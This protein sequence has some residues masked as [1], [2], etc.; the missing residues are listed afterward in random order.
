VVHSN[1]QNFDRV[2][3]ASRR[4]RRVVTRR[5]YQDITTYTWRFGAATVNNRS[6]GRV[7]VLGISHVTLATLDNRSRRRRVYS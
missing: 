7:R 4:W 6:P 2:S 5:I 3:L 1:R